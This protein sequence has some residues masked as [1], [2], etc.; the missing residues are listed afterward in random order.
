MHGGVGQNEKY[1][2]KHAEADGV[3]PHVRVV[4][5]EG[6][7]DGGARD[8]DV[9]AVLVVAEAQRAD[10]VDDQALEAVVEDGELETL[11]IVA[12]GG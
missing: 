4:E 7:E 10:L 12:M 3:E 1:S 9:D 8:L 5:A 11:M 6:A 2:A